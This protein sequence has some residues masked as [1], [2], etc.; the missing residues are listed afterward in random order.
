MHSVRAQL[1]IPLRAYSVCEPNRAP[2]RRLDSLLPSSVFPLLPFS[3]PRLLTVIIPLPC[4]HLARAGLA[5]LVARRRVLGRV[6]SRAVGQ[7]R[8]DPGGLNE[9]ARG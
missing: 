3:P 4:R 6:Q 5:G 8:F 1:Q 7:R 2:E 9:G